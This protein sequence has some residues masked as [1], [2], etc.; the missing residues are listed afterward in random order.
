MAKGFVAFCFNFQLLTQYM[1]SVG[2]LMHV[3]YLYLYKYCTYVSM[4]MHHNQVN[5]MKTSSSTSY[6][7][8]H[9]YCTQVISR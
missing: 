4:K 1:Y 6:E 5:R 8:V 7:L 2:V 3:L 9:Y